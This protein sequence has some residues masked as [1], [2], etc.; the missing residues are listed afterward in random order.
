MALELTVTANSYHHDENRWYP[1]FIDS[2]E[3]TEH[4]QYG[5]GLKWVI[6]LDDDQDSAYPETWAFSSQNISPGSKVH[7]WLTQIYSQAPAVGVKVKLG[8][9]F[10]K[11]VAIKFGP[12]R[13]NPD[14]QVVVAFKSGDEQPKRQ[15]ETEPVTNKD[16][17]F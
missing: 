7:T 1:G 9:L 15:P 17:P 12:H 14:K 16:V 8:E 2:L 10:G 11:R 4:V 13:N 3:E 5:P 6:L